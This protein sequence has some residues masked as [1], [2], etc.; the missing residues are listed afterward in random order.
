MQD[1]S[2]YSNK[3]VSRSSCINMVKKAF[4]LLKEN[5]CYLY[6]VKEIIIDYVYEK[7][8]KKVKRRFLNTSCHIRKSR[9]SNKTL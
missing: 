1:F 7:Q 9:R 4:L 6:T 3:K 5:G 8:Y 2:C